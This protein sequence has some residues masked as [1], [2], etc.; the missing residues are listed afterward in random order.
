MGESETNPHPKEYP[1]PRLFM[2]DPSG[3]L[4]SAPQNLIIL[5]KPYLRFNCFI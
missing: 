2:I 3:A 4:K 5:F 1:V